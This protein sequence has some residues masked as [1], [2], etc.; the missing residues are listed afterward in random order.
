MEIIKRPI[1]PVNWPVARLFDRI[2]RF[3]LKF[4]PHNIRFYGEVLLSQLVQMLQNPRTLKNKVKLAWSAW[5]SEGYKGVF[6]KLKATRIATESPISELA[7]LPLQDRPDFA[8]H[9]SEYLSRHSS[10]NEPFVVLSLSYPVTII[11][12]IYRGVSQT[13]R[14]IESVLRHKNQTSHNIILI[15]DSS[16]EPEI[17]LLLEEF[18]LIKNV[19]ILKNTENLGFVKTVNIG[20]RL[21]KGSDVILLNSDTE[22]VNNWLDRLV[23]Q[24]YGDPTIGT[25]TPFSNNA[26][27]CSY[28]DIYGWPTLPKFESLDSLDRMASMANR[29]KSVDIPTAV[30]FCMYIKRSCLD[31]VGFFDE[32][33]FGKGYG[34]ENDFCLKSTQKGWRH[35]LATNVFVYHEGEVS[36]SES[37]ALKKAKAGEVIL[38]RYPNYDRIIQAH[39]R[40]NEAFIP[41]IALTASRYKHSSQPVILFIT[42]SLGGGTEKHV[43]DLARSLGETGLKSLILRPSQR[44][45]GYVILESIQDSEKFKIE[46]SSSKM[47]TLVTILDSFGIDKIHIHHTI[48]FNISLE[49]LAVLMGVPYDVTVHDYFPIC[50]RINLVHPKS[51]YCEKPTESDCNSCL[52]LD[53][54]PIVETDINWWRAS[55]ASLLNGSHAVYCPSGD[56]AARIRNYFPTTNIQV[57]PHETVHLSTE[58]TQRRFKRIAILGVLAEHKGLSLIEEALEEIHRKNLPIQFILIGQAMRT[59]PESKHFTQSGSY[60]DEDLSDLILSMNP[61]AILFPSKCPETYSYTL[62]KAICSRRPIISSNIG[63]IPERL[64]D[65]KQKYIFPYNFSGAELANYLLNLSF[66][67]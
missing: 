24:A 66:A 15:N 4:R 36:F 63:A 31:D 59:L 48:G 44:L 25:V 37:A 42:H 49:K 3:A 61:D 46:F 21:A 13:R 17:D 39:I 23:N 5:K 62:T 18:S 58:N 10:Q 64:K 20:M 28:P 14:C 53:P 1:R 22:V 40:K 32:T 57:V 45:Y 30:G 34:E 2:W 51:G 60:K 6:K 12:P 38:Q 50:P 41:R 7:L 27:I 11:I 29:D 8:E 26:T 56:T 19:Q 35:I 67:E 47:S 9:L 55:F 33:A 54:K 65:L 16:P 52:I 43:A